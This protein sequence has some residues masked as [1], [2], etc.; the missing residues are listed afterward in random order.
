MVENFIGK[1]HFNLWYIPAS[2]GRE[3][4]GYATL[5]LILTIVT[6]VIIHKR[7]FKDF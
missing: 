3:M 1:L 2:K 7:I 6:G 4:I 5:L